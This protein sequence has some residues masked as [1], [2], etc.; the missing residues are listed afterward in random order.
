MYTYRYINIF[1]AIFQVIDKQE[2]KK[3]NSEACTY[4][5]GLK[6]IFVADYL[7]DDMNGFFDKVY[8]KVKQI[9]CGKV[10]T[11]GIIARL[12]G[13][14]RMSRQVGWA[15]HVNPEPYVIPCHRVVN[16]EGKLAG[17]FAFGGKSIQHD[18][19]IAE[20]VEFI[21]DDTV[22]LAKHIWEG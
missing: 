12:C 17:A 3:Y 14:K 5:F 16:R 2:Q 10:T 7:A 15:L 8:E 1:F 6:Y 21:D 11:Y 13:N 19:L 18:L 4:V 20:G 22:N 9:P